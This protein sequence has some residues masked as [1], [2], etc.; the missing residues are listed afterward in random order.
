MLIRIEATAEL[1]RTQLSAAEKQVADSASR[2]AGSMAGANASFGKMS[3]AADAAGA[4]LAK[5]AA[6]S[7]PIGSEL[8]KLATGSLGVAAGMAAIAAAGAAA[9]AGI[10]LA[11]DAQNQIM[12]R[13]QG[14]TGSVQGAQVAYAALF[15]ISQQ[16]GVSVAESAAAFQKFTVATQGLGATQTDVLKMVAAV[17]QAGIV[18]GASQ[19]QITAASDALALGLERGKIQAREL[20][21]LLNDAPQFV[22]QIAAA[23]GKTVPQLEAM[24]KA[25]Q[26][27]SDIL[28]KGI[29]GA[30]TKVK[31]QF[32]AM[33][34]SIAQAG[35]AFR[36]A[37]EDFAAALDKAVYI[38]GILNAVINSAGGALKEATRIIA[39]DPMQVADANVAAAAAAQDAAAQHL[40][41]VQQTAAGP[42]SFMAGPSLAA[43]KAQLDAANKQFADAETAKLALQK[44]YDDT[45][46][47]QAADAAG[48]ALAKQGSDADTSFAKLNDEL[49][50]KQKLLADHEKNLD[51]IRKAAALGS[52]SAAGAATATTEE[53]QRYADALDKLKPK[54]DALAKAEDAYAAQLA[55][56]EASTSLEAETAQRLYEVYGKGKD[57]TDAL[58]LSLAQEAAERQ[59]GI[60][61][62]GSYT[63]AQQAAKTAIDA[64][65]ASLQDYKNKLRDAEQANTEVADAAKKVLQETES[66]AKSTSNSISTAIVD[67]LTDPNGAN[68]IR[69]HF[70]DLFKKIAAS[71]LENAII[72]PMVQQ[73]IGLGGANTGVGA[74]QAIAAAEYQ[75]GPGGM[76]AGTYVAGAAGGGAGAGGT[77]SVGSLIQLLSL[78]NSASGLLGGPSL[79]SSLGSGLGITGPGGLSSTVLLSNVGSVDAGLGAAEGAVTTGGDLTLGGAVSALGP[80]AFGIGA[81]MLINTAIGGHQV[82]G[83]IGAVGGA[84]AGAAIGSVVPVIGTAI[85]AIVGAIIGA[86]SGGL[87]GPGKP[88]IAYGINTGVADNQ[89]A[90]S[91]ARGNDPNL[92]AILQATE[93]EIASVNALVSQYSLTVTGSNVVGAGNKAGTSQTPN[94]A[95]SN[96]QFTSADKNVNT[97]LGTVQANA[98][99]GGYSIDA[100][101]MQNVLQYVTQTYETL[102]KL[103]TAPTD[104]FQQAIDALNT[105]YHAAID[106]AEQYG[107]ATKALSAAQAANIALQKT[108]RTEAQA[109][110][111]GTATAGLQTSL[112]QTSAAAL[113][114]FDAQVAP[115]IFQLTQQLESVGFTSKQVAVY[116]TDL[117]EAFANTRAA[118]VADAA[119]QLAAAMTAAQTASESARGQAW[120]AQMDAAKAEEYGAAQLT[121]LTKQL[122]ALGATSGQVNAAV[123]TLKAGLDAQ[124]IALVNQRNTAIEA[125]NSSVQLRDM[126]AQNTLDP[127]SV[128]QEQIDLAAQAQAASTELANASA[129]LLAMGADAAETAAA[130]SQ[131]QKTQ[132]DERL[133]LIAKDN[134]ALNQTGMSIRDFVTNL[135]ATKTGGA[136][137]TDQLLA[138]QKAFGAQLALAK[139][140][141]T[142]ALGSITGSAST[143]LGAGSAMYGSGAQYQAMVQ[144][145]E[146]QLGHLPATASYDSE[147]LSA[148]KSIGGAIDVKAQVAALEAINTTLA[149]MGAAAQGTLT[150]AGT[151]ILTIEGQLGATLTP[152]EIAGLLSGNISTT[153]TIEQELAAVGKTITPAEEATLAAAFATVQTIN[154]KVGADPGMTSAQLATI[155]GAFA[156]I[157]TISQKVVS[158]VGMTTQDQATLAQAYST[159]QTISQGLAP[160]VGMSPA[161]M[162]TLAADYSTIQT[163]A[164]HMVTGLGGITPAEKATLA[165]AFASAQSISQ[166]VTP[167]SGMTPDQIATLL[168]ENLTTQQIAQFVANPTGAPL[169]QPGNVDVTV[170]QAVETTET[171]QISRSVDDKI[172]TQLILA[173]QT[174]ISAVGFLYG[175]NWNTTV[176]A[177]DKGFMYSVPTPSALG[178]VFSGG[179]V[180]GFAG[181]GI[182]DIANHPT[183]APLALFGEAG[184][185]A[186]MPLMRGPGGALGVRASGGGNA[187]LAGAMQ[188]MIRLNAAGIS[189]LR[190]E[191]Q[192][193]R[194]DVQSLTTAVRRAIAA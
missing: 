63:D 56:V 61:A 176:L 101:A 182:P 84:A 144:M 129:Q 22:V 109:L 2:I 124:T 54:V 53:D 20:T 74:S 79:L 50:K 39:P 98:I 14:L 92:A 52:L 178:N 24:S 117:N 1:L 71:A 169:V 149:A 138:A 179:R 181:G 51:V 30:G 105:S 18:A 12:A 145:V 167:G 17:Q 116:V 157:Q 88:N 89:I 28:E 96:Y 27:T 164:Q 180:V 122:V 186:I 21:T 134:A 106:T 29:L 114:T 171:V 119:A 154:Q 35:G 4:V 93:S 82:G 128:T 37:L 41:Q 141:N 78:G 31:E 160:G 151:V 26:L 34:Q 191:M 11:G 189:A 190:A 99:A 174:L 15:D 131:L 45:A 16:T 62:I 146:S 125:F 110:A 158:G 72:L 9:A 104:Q 58:N 25:G 175:I 188:T 107:L 121:A 194:S 143:L 193:L 55:G 177:G 184:P 6:Q 100:T 153:Q 102:N 111:G 163:I 155:A 136:S 5:L 168:Q 87:F 42:L 64:S 8:A 91:A 165:A 162:A 127:N 159:I 147:V 126:T 108:Q 33:P 156:T 130:M 120:Q 83:D 90:I 172:N 67:G 13:L 49:D 76:A 170:K 23:L 140:G 77:S 161:D 183:Y 57:A 142:T 32:D 152:T 94:F 113:T 80:A 95:L 97:A 73:V 48:K 192:G 70:I 75:A 103:P 123:A 133:A 135:Q 38:S 173:N 68:T 7:G 60:P 65:V 43:A 36:S 46:A 187:D 139:A 10:A 59:A 118:M 166:R 66:F 86:V 81:G 40:G 185:E 132:S 150:R 44:A 69:T 112:G 137:P 85:G 19:E 3:V 115:A 148:L 47:K